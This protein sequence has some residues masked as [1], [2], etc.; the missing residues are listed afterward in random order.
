MKRLVLAF[1]LAAVAA[2]QVLTARGEAATPVAE[3]GFEEVAGSYADDAVSGLCASLTPSARWASGAFGGALATGEKGAGALVSGIPAVDGADSCSLFLRFRAEGAGSGQYPNLLTSQSWSAK[4]GVMLFSPGGKS[5]SVRVRAGAK[6]PETGWTAF[7]KMPQGRWSSV[8][9]VFSR[10]DVAVYADGKKVASGKWDHPF[11]TGGAVQLGGWGRDSFGG[12]IDDFRVW[13]GALTAAQVAELAGDSRYDEIEGYQDDGTGGI[14]KT[15]ILGQG[16]TPLHTLD[17]DAA[18]LTFDTLG[19]VSSIRERAG[20][21]ELVTNAT[22]FVAARLSD[23]S[24]VGARRMEVRANGNLAFLFGR[25]GEVVLSAKPFA[26][27]WTFGVVSSTLRDVK[28]LELCRVRPA[29]DR[30]KGDFAN[31]WSD[32]RSAVCV[33]SYDI[34]GDPLCHGALRVAVDS[35]FPA[36]GRRVGLAAGPR[37]GFI[38]QLRAMTVESGAPRG[39]SGGAW[40]IGS[41][42]SRWSYVFA[43]VVGGDIDSWIEYVKRAGFANLHIDSRWTDCRGQYPVSR[44]AFPGGLEEMKACAAKARAAGLRVGMHTLTACIDPRDSWITPVCSEEL[45]ADATYTLAAPLAEDAQELLVNEEPIAKHVNVFTYSSSGNVLRIGGELV[46]YT[47]IDRARRPY[48]FTGIKRGAF[49]TRKGGAYPAGTKVDYLH[50]RYIAF[51]PK[52]GSALAGKLSDRLAEVYNTCGL[53]EFYFDG[54]EGMGT[55]YGIDSMRH[56]IYSKL[57]ANNGHS[58]SIEASCL[59]ANNWWFQTRMATTDHGLYG[60]KRFHDWHVGWAIDRGRISNFLEP[61]M[62]WW[63]PRTDVP[64]A[65]GHMLDEMEYFASRNAG[66]DAA[67]SIEGIGPRRDVAGVRRQLTVLGWHEYPRLA[68]AFDPEVAKVFAT[69]GRETRLR[70]GDDGVWRV[71]EVAAS[72]HRAAAPRAKAWTV[73]SA[74][75]RP[76]ALRVEALYAAG[77]AKD[78]ETLLAAGMFGEM[79]TASAAGV[80]ASFDADAKGPHGR[81]FRLSAENVSAERKGAWARAAKDFGFS[82]AD[83][84]KD[85]IA[86]GAW[87]KG[88]GSGALLNLQFRTPGAFTGGASDHYVRLDFKGWKYVTVL[89]RERDAAAHE[90]YRWPYGGYLLIY[91]NFVDPRHLGTFTAY[92]NDVPKGSRATVEIGEVTALPQVPRT[93]EGASV[94]I[95]GTS[96]ALPFALTSGEYAELDGGRWTKYSAMGDALESVAAERTP[97][98]AAGANACELV[99]GGADARAEVTVFGLGETRPALV[100]LTPEMKA[101]M[102]YEGVMPFEYSPAKGLL[103]PESIAVRPGEK[104]RLSLELYGPAKSPTFTFKRFFGL[105]KTVCAFETEIAADERLVCRDGR[106]WLVE[107]RKTGEVVRKGELAEPLPVLG[108]TTDFDFAAT[109]TGDAPCVVDLLKAY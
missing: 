96:F 101:T 65:R 81:A 105:S 27:G 80:K 18:T 97:M 73:E 71:T 62:G 79:K 7:A 44:R 13:K 46:Q 10:P 5:L 34:K 15:A 25:A 63:M 102:R 39:D 106:A 67:M 52:P 20:G 36:V 74:S 11:V 95:G 38:G 30:W 59:G 98:L 23:G 100:D 14:R 40:S 69:P 89:L 35:Q 85:R 72:V 78:G 48:A 42:A 1:A 33:R 54:S 77:E 19:R 6:G 37:D 87:V 90:D 82:G 94:E 66:H 12:L 99:G 68:R 4:G 60:V 47:G 9:F 83:L 91:R 22:P 58:P 53:D 28:T 70:Q 61:Q 3:F 64:R 75:A 103:A 86:F 108:K 43:S 31:A 51:Y 45:V 55:R 84:G 57:K 32:E 21:R 49:R 2:A 8:A 41:E 109:L 16:G 50:Q 107:K 88:D 26:G 17:G 76:A 56:E 29:C 104:A 24:F 92:L 93:I